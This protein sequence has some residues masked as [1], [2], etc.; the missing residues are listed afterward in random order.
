MVLNPN[1]VFNIDDIIKHE[2][3]KDVSFLIL[4]KEPIHFS[5]YYFRLNGLW[6]NNGF[7][8]SFPMDYGFI[9]I[10]EDHMEKWLTCLEPDKDCLRNS[11]WSYVSK[12]NVSI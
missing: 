3:F 9:I 11:K 5:Q 10:R 6:I 8:E 7:V 2:I 1:L 12:V 4:K